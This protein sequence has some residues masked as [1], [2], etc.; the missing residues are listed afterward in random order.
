[1]RFP[2]LECPST[3]K[4]C[5]VDEDQAMAAI[6]HAWR[7]PKWKATHGRMP[8]R[9]FLCECGWWHMTNKTVADE[10]RQAQPH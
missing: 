1:M 9:A 6:E 3:G 10:D 2:R 4:T 5:F 8:T 7:K